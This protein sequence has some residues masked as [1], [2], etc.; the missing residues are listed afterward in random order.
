[1]E[2]LEICLRQWNIYF[3]PI[4]INKYQLNI[5]MI[6]E[7]WHSQ[8]DINCRQPQIKYLSSRVY[9]VHLPLLVR[10][11]LYLYTSTAHSIVYQYYVSEINV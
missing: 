2:Q 11:Q 9:H 8:S 10:L 1:M 3:H 5:Y 7:R 4:I 6:Q